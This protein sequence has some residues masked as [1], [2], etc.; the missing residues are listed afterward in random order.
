MRTDDGDPGGVDHDLQRCRLTA[1]FDP[2]P[3]WGQNPPVTSSEVTIAGNKSLK[4]VW[5]GPDGLYQG[6]TGPQPG[7][8][9]GKGKL[10]IDFWTPDVTSVKVSII[11]PGLE[12]AYTQVLTTGGW[13]SVD[14]DL[15]N[16]SV[17]N[18]ANIIQ[19]KLEPAAPGHAVRRQ[20][21][22]LGHFQGGGGGAGAPADMGSGGPQTLVLSS[23]DSKGIF[24]AGEAIFAVDYKGSLESRQL[25][26]FPEATGRHARR[27]QHRL[28][29]R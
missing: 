6:S 17:P 18:K 1:G 26:G 28:F 20:H 21:L 4:Y 22:L 23:G 5:P 19:I 24:V 16:Y 12:N 25:W 10:H 9:L 11:S 7:G 3:Y 8:C 29:Q 15:S 14:I 2:F 13:N 27:R